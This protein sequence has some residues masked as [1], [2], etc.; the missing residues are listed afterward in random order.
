MTRF[1]YSATISLDGYIAGPGGDMTW[2]VPYLGPNAVIDALIPQIGALLVG[3]RTFAGDDPYR[4]TPHEGEPFGG[5]WSG[6]QFVLTRDTSL[7]SDHDDL[8]FVHDLPTAIDLAARAAGDAYVNV[9]G[10]QTARA[11]LQ[12]GRLDDVLVSIAPIMLGGG[13][14]LYELDPARPVTLERTTIQDT[15]LGITAWYRVLHQ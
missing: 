7:R 13:T 8:T 5:G 3:R 14:R 1:I 10:A 11:C 2:M 15:P 4:D 12:T 9:L 6:P